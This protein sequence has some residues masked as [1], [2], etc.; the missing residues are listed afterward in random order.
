MLF[1]LS[2]DKTSLQFPWRRIFSN[3]VDSYSHA[4]VAEGQRNAQVVA[5]AAQ[6]VCRGD[7]VLPLQEVFPGL[8]PRAAAQDHHAV[9]VPTEFRRRAP[10]TGRHRHGNPVRV[11]TSIS[12]V[13]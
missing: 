6:R 7:Q 12:S 11:V 9:R 10:H 3:D 1:S 8:E 13:R 2:S 5:M 4:T